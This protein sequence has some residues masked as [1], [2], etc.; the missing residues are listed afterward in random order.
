MGNHTVKGS[1]TYGGQ[2]LYIRAPKM[3][4][5]ADIAK[6]GDCFYVDLTFD[7]TKNN[8]KFFNFVKNIDYSAI[9]EIT[10]N[11]PLWYKDPANVSLIQVEQEYI[12]TVKLSTMFHDRHSMKLKIPADKIEFYDQDDINVPYQLIK[13]NY[14]V[15]PLLHLI[16]TYKDDTHIWTAWELPQLKVVIPETVLTECHLIDVDDDDDD[17]ETH[18]N[19]DDILPSHNDNDV[20]NKDD[21]LSPTN[22][23]I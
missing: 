13:E 4:L 3:Y 20:D 5:G 12:P 11:I 1:I 18:P 9:A 19:D 6:N 7:K 15:I 16:G 2:P 8:D 22:T 21:S 17:E 23:I 10:E 14:S